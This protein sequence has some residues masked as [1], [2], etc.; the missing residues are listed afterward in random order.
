MKKSGNPYLIQFVGLKDGEH[1]FD[2]V[3]DDAFFKD[4]EYSEVQ[5]AHIDTQVILTKATHLL[6]FDIK[7]EGTINVPCDRCGDPFDFPVWGERKLVVSLTNDKFDDGDDIVSL[8]LE[9]SEIDISQT[10]Y[11]YINLLLPQRRIH[12]VEEDGTSGCN[13]NAL[14]TLN[15]LSEKEEE[16]KTDPRWD[17]LK[18]IQ[19]N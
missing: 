19:Q 12:P 1:R 18:K 17:A 14:K 9:A 6:V 4:R 2:Y 11:E 3:I 5:K 7:M 16:Q 8:S 15:K 13:E 10:L